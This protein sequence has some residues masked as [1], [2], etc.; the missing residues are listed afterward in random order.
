MG[1]PLAVLRLGCSSS[2]VAPLRTLPTT[3]VP[4]ISGRSSPSKARSGASTGA[5]RPAWV[6]R[7]VKL[8][9]SLPLAWR[10]ASISTGSTSAS[11]VP[12]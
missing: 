6:K 5:A 1:A 4:G 8:D 11:L 2:T 9:R 7:G 10:S 12:P 3:L